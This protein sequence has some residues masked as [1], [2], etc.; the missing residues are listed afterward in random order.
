MD[1]SSNTSAES[2]EPARDSGKQLA[3]AERVLASFQQ[4]LNHDLPNQMV[5]IQG[6]LQ[7]LE[8]EEGSRLSAEGQDYVRRLAAVTRRVQDMLATLKAILKA[9][10]EPGPAEEV[11]L[12][13]LA[14]EVAAEIKQLCPGRTVTYHVRLAALTVKARRGPLHRALVEL[15]RAVLLEKDGAECHV[16]VESRPVAAGV[17]LVIGRWQEQAAELAQAPAAGSERPCANRL[18]LILARELADTWGGTLA[19]TE[20]V[21]H[22]KLFSVLVPV[23]GS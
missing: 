2:P 3:R 5:A 12:A 10:A 7:V 6:L 23:R 19:V 16:R 8:L 13:D 15:I 11:A 14:R 9:G 21:G 22:G 20:E 4:V 17:E 1:A 18:G